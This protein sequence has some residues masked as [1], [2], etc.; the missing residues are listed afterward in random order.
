M[1]DT[2]VRVLWDRK[3]EDGLPSLTKPDPFFLSAYEKCVDRFFP[4]AGR[5]LDLAA[6]LGRHALWLAGKGWSVAAVDVSEVAIGKLGQA[7]RQLQVAID[8]FAI[9]AQAYTFE[10]AGFDLVVL[11]Y[12]F[13]RHLFPR[14]IAALRPGGLLICKMALRWGPE[15]AALESKSQPLARHEILS[16]VPFLEVIDCRE[17]PIRDRGVLE[18]VG[19]K[20]E[21]MSSS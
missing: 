9:D 16:L 13:D 15:V 10:P 1:D 3:F 7:A 6:G 21:H 17:R 2:N 14:I 11:F 4:Q 18:F 20:P 8:L 5:A 19:R 12:H